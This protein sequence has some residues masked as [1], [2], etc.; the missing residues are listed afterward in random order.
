[1]NLNLPAIAGS[2]S[3]SIIYAN[4]YI[5]YLNYS[6]IH[7]W[8]F[9]PDSNRLLLTASY[10]PPIIFTGRNLLQLRK[11]IE[12]NKLT[13]LPVYRRGYHQP[14]TNSNKPIIT[15]A[16]YNVTDKK[17]GK[18]HLREALPDIPEVPEMGDSSMLI[19]QE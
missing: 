13:S 2:D 7:P 17:T 6:D 9:S 8:L 1:M 3:V 16:Y 12:G 4:G 14:I 15:A 19:G 11:H 18:S 5:H 10:T